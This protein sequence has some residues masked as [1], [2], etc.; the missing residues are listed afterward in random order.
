[1]EQTGKDSRPAKFAVG[2]RAQLGHELGNVDREFVGR[3]ILARVVAIA[4][5]ETEVGEIN[6]IA[7]GKSSP[8]F[9]R[10]KNRAVSFAVAAGIADCH[11]PLTFFDQLR[12]QHGSPPPAPPP[13]L[14]QPGQPPGPPPPPPRSGKRRS[15]WSTRTRLD[16]FCRKCYQPSLRLPRKYS[17]LA[18][19]LA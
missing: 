1:L 3:R 11:L 7:L 16:S 15:R 19:R 9:H 5:I 14:A 4:A 18:G 2:I 10:G 13:S 8:P 6:Q 12:Q 17:L